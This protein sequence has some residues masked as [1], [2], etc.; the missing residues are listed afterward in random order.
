MNEFDYPLEQPIVR[1][2]FSVGYRNY[3]GGGQ[4]WPVVDT[5]EAAE[6]QLVQRQAE[7]ADLHSGTRREHIPVSWYIERISTIRR[8][9]LVREI[10]APEQSP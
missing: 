10:P 9:E 2:R 8:V 4:S 3:A 1:D 7:Y 6:S 5:L